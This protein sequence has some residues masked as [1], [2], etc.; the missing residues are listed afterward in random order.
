MKGSPERE[1]GKFSR[2]KKKNDG[3]TYYTNR[4]GN[5]RA[6]YVYRRERDDSSRGKGGSDF[7]EEGTADLSSSFHGKGE[8]N[9]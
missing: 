7:A 6:R 1:G 9:A 2:G 8:E 4:T 3:L 5:T